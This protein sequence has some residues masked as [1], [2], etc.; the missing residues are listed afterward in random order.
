MSTQQKNISMAAKQDVQRLEKS[1]KVMNV[2]YMLTLYLLLAL[3]SVVVVWAVYSKGISAPYMYIIAC[4]TLIAG[5][6]FR[7]FAVTKIGRF[8]TGLFA[9]IYSVFWIWVLFNNAITGITVGNNQPKV[10]PM[11]FYLGGGLFAVATLMFIIQPIV[12][13]RRKRMI[14]KVTRHIPDAHEEEET[15]EPENT[16]QETE[17]TGE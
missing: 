16:A 6:T 13:I 14:K 11:E 2:W 8:I 7:Y 5:V 15:E 3:G 9:F 4:V 17:S 1:L 12:Q 10:I